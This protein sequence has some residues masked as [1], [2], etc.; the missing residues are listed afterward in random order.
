MPAKTAPHLGAAAIRKSYRYCEQVAKTRAKNFYYS[1]LLLDKPKREAMC[2]VYAFMRHC[3]DL[4]DDPD[5]AKGKVEQNISLWRVELD[6]ALNGHAAANPLWPAFCDTVHR[7]SI[8]HRFFHEMIDGVMSDVQPQQM[9]TYEDLYEYCY[10]VA[11]VV[12]LTI[13]HI[14]GFTSMRALLLAEKCGIAFQIT[15]ILR[16]IREDAEMGRIYLPAEDLRRFGVTADQ[17]KAGTENE[18]FRH[19]MRFEASRAH[20]CYEESAELLR[21]IDRRSRRSLWALRSIYQLLLWKIE[22]ANFAVLSKRINVSKAT[23]VALLLLAFL[24]L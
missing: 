19:L 1:F 18:R 17:L 21:L 12:G 15:N 16:D 24:R 7:Y 6:R 9:A 11:S 22:R 10:K 3:D 20:A 5:L 2:A 13:I 14:F 4:S 8:P 23:K